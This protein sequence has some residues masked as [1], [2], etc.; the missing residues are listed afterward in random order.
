ML[1]VPQLRKLISSPALLLV[2][3]TTAT[4]AVTGTYSFL[5]TWDDKFYIVD[6]ADIR[7]ITLRHIAS[8]FSSFYVG[9]YA[10]LHILSYMVD[11]SLWR[12][13]PAGYHLENVLLHAVNGVLFYLILRRLDMSKWQAAAA[14]WIFLLHP[15]QVETVAWISQ[16]K[17]IL[18]MLF[19]LLAFLCY[20]EYRGRHSR[21]L[22][23]Y[24]V[25]FLC[26]LAAMLTK[27]IAVI[28]PVLAM[29]YDRTYVRDARAPSHIRLLDKLPFVL[30]AAGTAALTLVSQR[31]EFRGGLAA[32]YPGG[33][34]LATFFTMIPVL[35]SYIVD[36]FWPFG[37]KPY[38]LVVVRQYPDNIFTVSLI[39]A[40]VLAGLGAWLYRRAPRIL[41]WYALFFIALLPVMQIIPL[42]TQKQDRYL[43]FPLLGFAALVVHAAGIL[44]RRLPAVRARVALIV[45]TAVLASLPFLSLH[46]SR[47]W[48]NDVTLWRYATEVDPLSYTAW[49]NLSKAYTLRGDWQ[50]AKKAYD[51]SLGDKET[52]EVQ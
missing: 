25:S 27:S 6:N 2:I 18:S 49:E 50:N 21:K 8:A 44:L 48:E 38:Y 39:I 14:S 12:L 37:L 34:P 3:A 41:F 28:F 26:M 19:T 52:P 42:V 35:L 45:A 29:L 11:Y 32:V 13:S 22:A 36:C 43:Y 4:F 17:N 20:V 7:G 5:D 15:V 51:R 23:P 30:A 47:I 24:L 1:S 46:Q 33:S 10:P 16:R 9:N 31:A 40:C